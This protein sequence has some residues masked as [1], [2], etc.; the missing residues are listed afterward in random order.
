VFG[1]WLDSND[2]IVN[3]SIAALSPSKVVLSMLIMIVVV[4]VM[5][6]IAPIITAIVTTPIIAPVVWATV[7]L[8]GAGSLANIFLDLLV[9]LICI[10]PLLRHREKVLNRIGPLAK[11]FGPQSIMVA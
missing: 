8:V 2:G 7:L 11:K 5:V 9:G 6:V 10:S 1:C 4:V 3:W